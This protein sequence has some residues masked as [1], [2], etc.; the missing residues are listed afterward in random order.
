M[1]RAKN[2]SA[3][4]LI[5]GLYS[6]D[7][8]IDVGEQAA[9]LHRVDILTNVSRGLS[10]LGV[11]DASLF[12]GALSMN[13]SRANRARCS[14]ILENIADKGSNHFR[15]K[16]LVALGSNEFEIGNHREAQGY[17]NEAAR[18]SDD[19]LIRLHTAE[20]TA[21]IQ[22]LDGNHKDA[23]QG[24][25]ATLGL[26]QK[27]SP[28]Y[29]NHLNSLAV[30]LNKL[31]RHSEALRVLQPC[32]ASPYLSLYPEWQETAVEIPSPSRSTIAIETAPPVRDNSVRLRSLRLAMKK[33]IAF[34]E[35]P[36]PDLTCFK[37]SEQ[38]RKM[39]SAI[40]E[41]HPELSEAEVKELGAVIKN[42]LE[43]PEKR[44]AVK[45]ILEEKESE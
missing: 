10:R 34:P 5:I 31:G 14:C 23:L 32:L 3:N 1:S 36:A 25:V 21:Q 6:L 42:W 17:Y 45:R 30:E 24:L 18:L 26:A 38:L 13:R 27:D 40:V 20:M 16:A 44:E 39:V 35:K 28:H 8:L 29:F 15:A 2:T 43:Q 9:A 22:S 4:R 33:I 41:E 11:E 19:P 7:R 12:Y 37:V